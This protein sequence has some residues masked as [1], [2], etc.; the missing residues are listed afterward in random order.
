MTRIIPLS[1]IAVAS[2]YAAEVELAPISVEST[3][4]TEVA[5]N[6][7][8]SSDL[9][10]ALSKNV[11]SIDMNRRSGIA[12]DILIRGQKRDNI[13]VTTDGTKVCGACVNRM[14]PPTSHILASQI[15]EI[16]VIEGP[17]DVENFGTLSGGIKV[18][19]KQ[20]TQAMHGEVN[21]GVGSWG[22][23][24]IGA[25]VSG[26]NEI[27]RVLIS[28][29]NESSEQYEDGNG[30]TITEQ[31]N[32]YA[33][34]NLAAAPYKYADRYS[35]MDE[36]SKKSVMAKAFVTTA[37]DQELRLSYTANRSDNVLYANSKMD[38]L[39]DD[40]NIYSVEYNINNISDIYK[41][42]NLQYY[43][44]D[45]DHPMQTSYRQ[46]A[47]DDANADVT[48]HLTT[49][50]QGLKLKNTLLLGSH[51]LL[52]GLDGS[53]RTWDGDYYR[54]VSGAPITGT[55]ATPNPSGKSINDAETTNMAIFAQLEKQYGAL[56]V[57]VGARY[58]SSEITHAEFETN[59]YTALSA[60]LMTSYTL[61][62]QNRIFFGFG[63]ASR[64]PD[65]RELYFVSSKGSR[66]GT[67][68]LDQTINQEV[69]LGY[70]INNDAFKFKIKAFYSMLE[71]YIYIKKG[72][73]SSA[74]QNIDATIYGAE[75]SASYF[76]TDDITIDMGAS[77]KVGEKDEALA[78][79]EDKDLADIA[80]LRGNIALNY[81][82]M[83][84][85]VAT[86]EVLASDTWDTF[87]S[88]NGEQEIHAWIVPN[89]KVKHA[90][91]KSFDFTIGVNNILDNTY[92]VSN[93]YV[94]LTLIL[95]D[96]DSVMLM[97]EPGRYFYTNLDFKF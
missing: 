23:N 22:Y 21:Y 27:V 11:P 40:S 29:S 14:D 1:L 86:F 82:Y 69:D 63:Q 4:I 73:P 62:K 2:L 20:P 68:N 31:M 81:E 97:N 13:S 46:V 17:Y 33:D 54:T 8:V 57:S 7:K 32:N 12:N 42:V 47:E 71:D 50:M 94:D 15:D 90:V 70:E 65:A 59:D 58:D 28:A 39:Y 60:N 48:N 41:N 51:E 19:T 79:Q 85:S 3:V 38:A 53:K 6:A 95:S 66:I 16:E 49:S 10:E 67:P 84:N 78:G 61:D 37:D 36:Y 92:A 35:D 5:E 76:A 45:V 64:I 93:T 89:F 75:L 83:N 87:D 18:K 77:Y 43:Y 25:T 55:P 56:N 34:S 44:S 30:D 9:A 80:P 74:F 91:N 72:A 24:K 96:T 52:V 88:S 26:G